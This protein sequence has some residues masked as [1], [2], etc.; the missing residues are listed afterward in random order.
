MS[1]QT[2]MFTDGYSFADYQYMVKLGRIP[3]PNQ[4]VWVNQEEAEHIL[5]YMSAEEQ[6]TWLSA[7]LYYRIARKYPALAPKISGM[8]I[9]GGREIILSSIINQSVLD[10]YIELSIRV[11]KE[12]GMVTESGKW[13]A[14]AVTAGEQALM[15][16]SGFIYG[17][18][19]YHLNPYNNPYY[20]GYFYTP[21]PT[22]SAE[23]KKTLVDNG[24]IV[25]PVC[26]KPV[27]NGLVRSQA[28][29][30]EPKK[31]NNRRKL[32]VN[33][34]PDC[35]GQAVTVCA[36]CRERGHQ[37]RETADPSSPI[38][39]PTLLAFECPHC[40]KVGHTKK[41]CPLLVMS[42]L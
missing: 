24:C 4:I 12:A 2:I 42:R 22:I 11:L 19:V 16:A 31:T 7:Q 28:Q 32:R 8:L 39:C 13:M 30:N 17:M 21:I 41:M 38:V 1:S 5:S 9:E 34:D 27:T 14:D 33:L 23:E 6:E 3:D 36:F 29:D 10:E 26:E 35:D 15:R 25:E 37:V 18:P 20:Q 40:G